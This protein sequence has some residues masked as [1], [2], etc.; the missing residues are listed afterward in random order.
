LAGAIYLHAG[1]NTI[2]SRSTKP[3]KH[4]KVQKLEAA[5]KAI[6]E[7]FKEQDARIQKVSDQVQM[8]APAAQI[9][10]ED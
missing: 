5:I 2:L 4:R 7:R 8:S 9:V 10:A 3:A 6:S 1:I